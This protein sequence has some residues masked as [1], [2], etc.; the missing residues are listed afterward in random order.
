MN[1]AVLADDDRVRL[2][3]I[4]GM[5]GSAHDGERAA[6]ALKFHALL[7]Q[8][9]LMPEDVLRPQPPAVVVPAG[10][11]TWRVAC[12]E[13]LAAHFGALYQPRE[14]DFITQLLADG[15]APTPRQAAWISK[16]CA[17]TGVPLWV[18]APR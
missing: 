2:V 10:P 7:Q 17:R 16:I 12:E 11:R 3:R 13:I 18:G 6:A 5:F 4:A 15:R 14:V 9:G 1:A 8:L